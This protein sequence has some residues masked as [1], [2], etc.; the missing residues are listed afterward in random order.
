MGTASPKVV[1]L[2]KRRYLYLFSQLAVLVVLCFDELG[3]LIVIFPFTFFN[4]IHLGLIIFKSTF[5]LNFSGFVKFFVHVKFFPFVDKLK[6][7]K[8]VT[9]FIKR[10]PFN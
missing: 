1:I 8:R 5:F 9:V 7:Y 4:V 3:V 2:H 6:N 10:V